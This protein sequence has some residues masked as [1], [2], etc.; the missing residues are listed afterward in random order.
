MNNLFYFS[1]TAPDGPPR[2]FLVDGNFPTSLSLQWSPPLLEH[3]NGIIVG[4][5]VSW[6]LPQEG[7]SDAPLG[8]ATTESTTYTIVDLDSSTIYNLSVAA[9]TKVGI[10]PAKSIEGKTTN[11]KLEQILV[12]FTVR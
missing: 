7:Q 3:Q 4:Y 6:K 8:T 11:S 2:S 1:F 9:F 12:V 5:Q 10:G